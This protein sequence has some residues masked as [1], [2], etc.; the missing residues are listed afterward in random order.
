GETL[1]LVGGTGSGK[2]TLTALVPRLHE[3]TGGRITLDGEDIATM[4]RSRLRELVSVAFEEPTLFSAT[5][6]EN[7]TMG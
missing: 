1:A 3:V 2:T 4:E 5:V 7:V 6:G